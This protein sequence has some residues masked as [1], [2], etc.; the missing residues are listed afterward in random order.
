[1]EEKSIN[2][3]YH[4]KQTKR[5]LY[6]LLLDKDVDLI[7]E[8]EADILYSLSIDEDIQIILRKAINVKN[9]TKKKS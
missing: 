5:K 4:L 1:M 9:Q 8:N 6:G 7:T 2:S 3:D